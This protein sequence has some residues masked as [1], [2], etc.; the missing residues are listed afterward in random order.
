MSQSHLGKKQ[1]VELSLRGRAAPDV[2]LVHCGSNDLGTISGVEL[3]AGMKQDLQ[4][5]HQ[6][7]N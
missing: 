4:H 5:L 3:V 1:K 6:V 7:H 2:L